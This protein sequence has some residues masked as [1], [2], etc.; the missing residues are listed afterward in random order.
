MTRR[1]NNP[2]ITGIG[3]PAVWGTR[4][5]D[6]LKG[7]PDAGDVPSRYFLVRQFFPLFHIGFSWE[8]RRPVQCQLAVVRRTI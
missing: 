7:H 8:S 1:S 5:D 2:I 3:I 4:P 6:A